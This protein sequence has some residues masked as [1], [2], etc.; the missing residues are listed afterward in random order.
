MCNCLWQKDNSI[1]ADLDKLAP[2]SLK[3]IAEKPSCKAGGDQDHVQKQEHKVANTPATP[4]E[5]ALLNASDC[6]RLEQ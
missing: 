1:A 6:V 3:H 2:A 5:A 4:L